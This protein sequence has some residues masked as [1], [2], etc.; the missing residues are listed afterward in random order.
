MTNL[1]KTKDYRPEFKNRHHS[2][3]EEKVLKTKVRH[4]DDP[5]Y[6]KISGEI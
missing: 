2:I 5:K 4:G 6:K 3:V 1:F